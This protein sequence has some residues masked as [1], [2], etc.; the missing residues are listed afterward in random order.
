MHKTLCLMY[1]YLSPT[2]HDPENLLIVILFFDKEFINEE[3]LQRN[4]SK[5]TKYNQPYTKTVIAMS[6]TVIAIYNF[7]QILMYQ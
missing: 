3:Q 6:L 1:N 5:Q 2:I 7:F 4:K